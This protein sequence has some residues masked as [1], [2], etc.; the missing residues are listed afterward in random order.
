M[1]DHVKK[2]YVVYTGKIEVSYRIKNSD[3]YI[4]LEDGAVV[5]G[6]G[7]LSSDDTYATIVYAKRSRRL[8][9]VQK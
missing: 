6:R 7:A 2:D 3:S 1:Q 5:Y 8:L 4:T 9:G